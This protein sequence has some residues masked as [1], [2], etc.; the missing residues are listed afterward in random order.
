MWAFYF[1]FIL[2]VL[3]L[4]I[5][6]LYWGIVISLLRGGWLAHG[7]ST[8]R[9]VGSYLLCPNTVLSRLVKKKKKNRERGFARH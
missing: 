9:F 2:G 8:V 1:L 5:S 6:R 4:V 7:G 3:R